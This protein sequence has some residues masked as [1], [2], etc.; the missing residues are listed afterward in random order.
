[1][2]SFSSDGSCFAAQESGAAA[3]E[4]TITWCP[5]EQAIKAFDES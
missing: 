4:I 5:S 1:M 2:W 3:S